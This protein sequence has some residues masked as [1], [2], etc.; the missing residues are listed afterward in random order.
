QL[1]GDIVRALVDGVADVGVFAENTPTH[2]LDVAPFQRDELVL[3][4]AP[5]HAL[6]GSGRIAFRECLGY[7]IVGLNRGSSLLELTARAAEHTGLP[8][9]LR[10]QVRSF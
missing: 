9:R 5:G 6:A 10:V 3:V 8:M 4:C 1:S 2:G 7:D